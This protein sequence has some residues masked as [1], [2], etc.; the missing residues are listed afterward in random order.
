MKPLYRYIEFCRNPETLWHKIESG[1]WDW[2]GVHPDGKFVL[3]RPKRSGGSSLRAA[4]TVGSGRHGVFVQGP[5][6]PGP[7][8]HL[9][10]TEQE[11]KE[12]FWREVARLSA[13]SEG[14]VLLRVQRV[15][16][17]YVEEEEFVVRRPPTYL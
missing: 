4:P 2:L 14:P 16:G 10:S 9:Y 17:V 8:R 3:G 15:V 1:D 12:G 5:L 11:A 7:T 6:D 13:E